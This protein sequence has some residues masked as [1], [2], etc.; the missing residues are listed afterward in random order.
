MRV[1]DG[2]E[3][4]ACEHGNGDDSGPEVVKLLSCS[5]QLSTKF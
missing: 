1:R 2:E 3:R 4:S 5:T